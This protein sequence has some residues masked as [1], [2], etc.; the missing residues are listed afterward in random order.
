MAIISTGSAS[1]AL[2]PGVKA[3]FGLSY[4]DHPLE[5][6]EIFDVM[7]SE[8]NFEEFV[9]HNGLG[10][11]KVKPETA[12]IDYSD[13]AQGFLKRFVHITYGHGYIISREA[14]EDNLY[15]DLAMQR[16][17]QL[18]RSMRLTKENVAANVLNRAFNSSYTGADGVELCSTAHL[19]SKGGTFANEL[20]VA[21]D[22]SE[23]SLESMLINIGKFTDDAGMQIDIK[24]QKLIIPVDLQFEAER[25]LASTLRVSTSDND[26]NA[27]KNKGML[28]MG[29]VVNHYLSDS[30][31]FFVK[32]DCDQGLMMLERRALMMDN[33][34]DFDSDNM[35]F[36]ATER[37][38]V[39]WV[40]PRC[41]YGS[42]GA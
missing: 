19:K 8:K 4:K 31:A 30:D 18:A 20:S 27:M 33:D 26:V 38:S 23:A 28:P 16:A 13:M 24:G 34:T 40:D 35:K 6:K 22:L 32:T 17:A 25:I 15:K 12:N 39:G 14:V 29:Y 2:F 41:I 11:A 10:L 9:N 5:Y 36:K 1:K 3:F 37:Y 21:A 42:P 7:A